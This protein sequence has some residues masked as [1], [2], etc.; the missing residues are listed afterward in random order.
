M[1]GHRESHSP[2]SLSLRAGPCAI[3][4][5]QLSRC[6]EEEEEEEGGGEGEEEEEG[7]G[8]G[9]EE[10]EEEAHRRR[11]RLRN[12]GSGKRQEAIKRE[13]PKEINQRT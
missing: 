9:K 10:E 7:P 5:L 11:I 3:W 4:C 6:E 8:G 1:Q 13:K 2:F 12:E